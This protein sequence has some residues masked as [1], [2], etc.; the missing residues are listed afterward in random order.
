[1][2][3]ASYLTI[4]PTVIDEEILRKAVN[5]Q[6]SPEIADVARREGI[7]FSSVM[8]LRLDYKNILKIDNLWGFESLVKLQLDNNIIE[9]IENIHF[10]VN[11]QWLGELFF[12]AN[13]LEFQ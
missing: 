3:G 6:V 9:R 4:E 2:S 10:L 1:M 8:S 12:Y 13:R 7:E 11:L 5:D